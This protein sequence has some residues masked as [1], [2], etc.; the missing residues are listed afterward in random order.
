M[1]KITKRGILHIV[2]IITY[3]FVLI[4]DLKVGTDFSL[5]AIITTL[6]FT[7]CKLFIPLILLDRIIFGKLNIGEYGSFGLLFFPFFTWVYF[8]DFFNSWSFILFF[9][10]NLAFLLKNKNGIEGI[11]AFITSILITRKIF[12]FVFNKKDVD[13]V[14]NN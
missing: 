14:S 6:F 8:F 11:V 13:S 12:W 2:F 3:V 1:N 5:P 9:K 4:N 7:F 10:N